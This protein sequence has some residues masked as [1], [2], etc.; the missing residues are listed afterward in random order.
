MGGEPC[1]FLGGADA[2]VLLAMRASLTVVWS[3][4]R[5]VQ[6]LLCCGPARNA[7]N[8]YWCGPVLCGE[9]V[10]RNDVVGSCSAQQGSA[11]RPIHPLA[12]LPCLDGS[13]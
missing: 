12:L 10:Q 4:S 8:P 7:C 3:C 1:A 9:N 11:T 6:A 13:S 2:V 5:C